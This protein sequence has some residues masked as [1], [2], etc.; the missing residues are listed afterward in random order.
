VVDLAARVGD[1]MDAIAGRIRAL[2]AERTVLESRL[3]D[4]GRHLA[5]DG[6]DYLRT[7]LRGEWRRVGPGPEGGFRV[8][9]RVWLRLPA[10]NE[11]ARGHQSAGRT[12]RSGS[13][14]L[15]RPSVGGLPVPVSAAGHG[16]DRRS[17]GR[18]AAYAGRR[19]D[20]TRPA[21]V[22]AAGVTTR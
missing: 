21:R 3:A 12:L 15:Q 13:G 20:G 10:G 17:R 6:R 19:I 4:L 11:N 5:E 1:D 18:D 16:A 8:D 2:R 7:L 14:G 9:G 22:G